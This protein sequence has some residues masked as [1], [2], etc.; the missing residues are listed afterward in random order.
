MNILHKLV[1]KLLAT[2]IMEE[3]IR[4]KQAIQKISVIQKQLMVD[5]IEFLYKTDYICQA[6]AKYGIN[7]KFNDMMDSINK[8]QNIQAH[9][10]KLPSSTYFFHIFEDYYGNDNKLIRMIMDDLKL[11][12]KRTPHLLNTISSDQLTKII[13]EFYT[14]LCPQI[15][16]CSLV[17]YKSRQ[18]IKSNLIKCVVLYANT[19]TAKEI[20][21][22]CD[23]IILNEE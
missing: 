18:L 6:Q 1:D 21:N 10:V 17:S 23:D 19:D 7:Y 8:L 22:K 4:R 3:A 11:S 16:S 14:W 13:K 2:P 12:A 5:L 15:E 20:I 9:E